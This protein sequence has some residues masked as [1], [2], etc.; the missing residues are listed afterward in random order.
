VSGFGIQ[1][2]P[3]GSKLVHDVSMQIERLREE[4][5]LIEME[6]TWFHEKTTFMSA[7]DVTQSDLNTINVY[8]FRGLFLISEGSLAIAL[9]LFIVLSPNFR[10]LIR[11][12]LQSLRMFL[13]H[14]VYGTEQNCMPVPMQ[15]V[16]HAVH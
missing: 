5:I 14:I 12:E 4:E 3:K 9:F 16:V 8:N 2:F 11:R 15:L 10:N 7:E 6:K 13:S 1:V